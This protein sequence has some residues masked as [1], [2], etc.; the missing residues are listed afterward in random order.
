MEEEFCRCQTSVETVLYK[1][2]RCWV[3]SCKLSVTKIWAATWQNQ[4][5]ECAPS[6]DSDQPGHPPN[7]IRVFAV[8]MKKAWVLSYP[9]NSEDS[10]QT[11]QMPRLIWVFTGCTVT[12][13]VLS[14]RGSIIILKFWRQCLLYISMDL[15]TFKA[16]IIKSRETNTL[17]KHKRWNNSVA[18]IILLFSNLWSVGW[19]KEKITFLKFWCSDQSVTDVYQ[20]VNLRY[21]HKE[22]SSKISINQHKSYFQITFNVLKICTVKF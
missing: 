19:S 7:L 2:S 18:L 3:F 15:L 8:R 20:T 10:D 12:L 22:N 4:Q 16:K 17:R 6:E 1:T 13:L 9:L 11:G 5:N 21:C 14:C